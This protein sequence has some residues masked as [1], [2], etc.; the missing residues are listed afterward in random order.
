L[1][2][3]PEFKYNYY[4]GI[5]I[6]LSFANKTFLNKSINFKV[7]PSY[8]IKSNS[9]SGSYSLNY[10]YLPENKKVNKLAFGIGGSH[11]NYAE[12]LGYNRLVP[13]GI[14]EFKKKNYRDISSSAIITSFTFVDKEASLTEPQDEETLKYNVFSVGYGFAKP[15]IIKDLRFS[16]ELQ[17]A[18]KFSKVALNA[19]YRI[20][21]NTN[22][23][24]DFRWFGGVFLSNN[25]NTD[26]FSFALDR[27]SDYLFRYDYLGRSETSG[28]F[29]Q[30]IIISEG[31]FKSKLP[32]N[33]ANQWL[34]SINTSIG[35]W[36]WIEIYNDAALVKNR[37]QSVY[38][39]YENGFRL[40]FVQDILEV[41]F[42]VYSNLG[43]EISQPSYATKIRFVLVLKPKRIINFLRRGFY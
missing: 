1:F 43:W 29:S 4:D 22:T 6:G 23:Q 5:I 39:A 11:F 36:R 7:T 34:T 19:H 9:F 24:F 31:G 33:Y 3:T 2:Y 21:T 15:N 18:D 28:F 25:T 13:Y 38:F 8:G 42:P 30:Q 17:V 12:D 20:L 41:Y 32:V 37:N 14:V 27:P 26:F 35:V 40:N 10:Q 16:S